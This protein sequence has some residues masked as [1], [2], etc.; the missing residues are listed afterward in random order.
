LVS[1]FCSGRISA[2]R[3]RVGGVTMDGQSRRSIIY[4]A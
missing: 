4:I 2:R 1:A 3:T